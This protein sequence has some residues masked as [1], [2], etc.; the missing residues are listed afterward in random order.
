MEKNP[1]YFPLSHSILEEFWGSDLSSKAHITEETYPYFKR[2]R[3]YT[4]QGSIVL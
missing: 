3:T 2:T 1:G 4:V